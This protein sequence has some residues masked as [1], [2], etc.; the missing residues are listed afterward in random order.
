MTHDECLMV[1]LEVGGIPNGTHYLM[2]DAA[3]NNLIKR[4]SEYSLKPLL[5][6]EIMELWVNTS[7]HVQFARLIEREHG[8]E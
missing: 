3:I 5:N 7:N 6:S 4:F 1:V 2:D 8:I